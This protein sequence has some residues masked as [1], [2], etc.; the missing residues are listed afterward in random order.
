MIR[1]LLHGLSPNLGG[2]ERYLHTVVHS[3]EGPDFHFDV[4]HSDVGIPPALRDDFRAMGCAFHP[5]TPRAMSARRN[6]A[7]LESLMSAGRFDVLHFN[8]TSASYLAPVRMALRHSIPV[9][10]H[11]HSAGG[12]PSLPTRVLHT[13]GRASPAMRRARRIAVSDPAGRWMFGQ[14]SWEV[15]E[16]GFDSAPYEFDQERRSRVRRDLGLGD[17]LIIGHVGAFLPA[18]NHEF[19]LRTFAELARLRPDSFLVLAGQGPGE[20]KARAQAKSLGVDDRVAFLGKRTD[21]SDLL[22]AMDVF[23]FPSTYEGSP[24]SVAEAQAAGL[25]TLVSEAV[26]TTMA[27]QPTLRLPLSAGPRR[28][29]ES[30]LAALGH[31]G[32]EPLLSRLPSVS[33]HCQQLSEV[34]RQVAVAGGK[35]G[36]QTGRRS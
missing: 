23:V 36:E 2:I 32:R 27:G 13:A 30:A 16:N 20:A 8:A 22:S 10:F 12:P 31:E 33:D 6:R 24:L 9:I 7:E 5:V 35:Q 18:K 21:V 1:V 17:Q 29:A 15:L 26:P 28:W 34:Y 11:S 19:L 25:P 3:L 4:T 14:R